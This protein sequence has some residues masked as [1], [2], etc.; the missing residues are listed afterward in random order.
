M[1]HC[2]CR[3]VSTVQNSALVSS[4]KFVIRQLQ[5]LYKIRA[6]QRQGDDVPPKICIF[7]MLTF[8]GERR[9]GWAWSCHTKEREMQSVITGYAPSNKFFQENILE[10]SD[11]TGIKKKK[12]KKKKK[13]VMNFKH[14]SAGKSTPLI[15]TTSMQAKEHS[16]VFL[17]SAHTTRGL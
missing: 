6:Y 9:S 1:R 15:H 10:N 2:Q 17:S 8:T 16:P 7:Q 14:A 4:L 5:V 3:D 12:K 13:A 11:L